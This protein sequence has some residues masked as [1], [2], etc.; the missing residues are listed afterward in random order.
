[1]GICRKKNQ[2]SDASEVFV[3]RLAITG[4]RETDTTHGMVS[5]PWLLWANA[6]THTCRPVHMQCSMSECR[7]PLLLRFK[8]ILATN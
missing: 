2:Q 8:I 7:S 5:V 6:N 1:M 3:Q 4:D